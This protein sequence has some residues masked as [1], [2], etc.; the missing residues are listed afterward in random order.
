MR[1]SLPGLL[2]TA[3]AI[4]VGFKLREQG[5]L[6]AEEVVEK[7]VSVKATP[8]KPGLPTQRI[9]RPFLKREPIG[10]LLIVSPLVVDQGD[11]EHIG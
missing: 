3:R 9:Y 4:F 2:D 10:L 6:L 11:A 8:R 7:G 1:A 5:S